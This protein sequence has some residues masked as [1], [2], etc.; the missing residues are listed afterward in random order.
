MHH[1]MDRWYG[2]HVM[3]HFYLQN[4]HSSFLT[5]N[6]SAGPASLPEALSQVG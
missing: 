3:L 1:N 4:E 5:E 6:L 2:Q